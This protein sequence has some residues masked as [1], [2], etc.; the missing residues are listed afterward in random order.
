MACSFEEVKQLNE[1]ASSRNLVLVENFQFRFHKQLSTIQN[2]VS[3]GV[4][5]NLRCIRSSFG[6]PPFPDE[7]NIRYKRVLGGGALFDA[8]AYPIKIVQIFLGH[9]IEVSASS[10]C[11]DNQKNVDIWGGAFLNQNNGSLFAEIAFGFDNFYQCNLELW[12]SEGKIYTKRIFTAPPDKSTEIIIESSNG[13]NVY[14]VTPC[15]HF[16]NMLTHFCN[17]IGTKEGLSAEYKQ[18]I[19]QSRLIFETMSM[20]SNKID[21]S[22]KANS[23]QPEKCI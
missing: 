2:L 17:L 4:I 11:Y 12:G 15:N 9:E 19:N 16:E 18:N 7:N 5:G 21:S 20:A 8:G 3:A 1:L 22:N 10:L 23:S 14:N 6:F 13:N